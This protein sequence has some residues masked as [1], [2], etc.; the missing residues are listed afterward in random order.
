MSKAKGT[1]M[2][3]MLRMVWGTGEWMSG[4]IK[5]I[6]AA[7]AKAVKADITSAGIYMGSYVSDGHI[8]AQARRVLN[9]KSH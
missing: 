7:A 5:Y 6:G 9:S 2:E 3:V 1:Y 4:I 8:H